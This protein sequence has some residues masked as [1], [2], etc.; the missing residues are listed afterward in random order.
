MFSCVN[1]T[2]FTEIVEKAGK[3]RSKNRINNRETKFS[4]QTYDSIKLE[5][6]KKCL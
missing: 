3:R 2:P 5:E 1:L 6:S 4:Y